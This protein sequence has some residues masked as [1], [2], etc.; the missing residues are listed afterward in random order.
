[1]LQ[2]FGEERFIKEIGVSV[3]QEDEY[4]QLYRKTFPEGGPD[5]VML[6]VENST[7][8]ADGSNKHYWLRVP[9]EMRSAHEAVAWTFSMSTE[10]Y[11]PDLAT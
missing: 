11:E 8:E 3:D 6:R 9:P 2:R 4:G 10:E 1:M 7:P 5:L